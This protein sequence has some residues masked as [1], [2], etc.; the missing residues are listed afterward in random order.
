MDIY[1]CFPDMLEPQI[2]VPIYR[3]YIFIIL[4]EGETKMWSKFPV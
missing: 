4:H 2:C 3:C 1:F